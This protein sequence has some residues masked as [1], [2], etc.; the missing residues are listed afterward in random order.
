MRKEHAQNMNSAHKH[1]KIYKISLSICLIL[2]F[3]SLQ[4]SKS[5]FSYNFLG[6]NRIIREQPNDFAKSLLGTIRE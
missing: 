3:S 1:S 5:S 4:M 2:V 6:S